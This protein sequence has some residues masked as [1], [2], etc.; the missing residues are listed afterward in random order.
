M[1]GDDELSP[2]TLDQV[3]AL[4]LAGA[5]EKARKAI[6]AGARPSYSNGRK[7][8]L[9]VLDHMMSKE[10]NIQ[11]LA[12]AIQEHLDTD[13]V[14]FYKTVVM[15]LTPKNYL[16]A[17]SPDEAVGGESVGGQDGE[18]ESVQIVRLPDNGRG[19]AHAPARDDTASDD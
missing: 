16:E 18:E 10:A 11:K 7:V 14:S 4:R 3:N 1:S 19:P 13:P 17:H 12:D 6:A 9:A 15:P 2:L 8:A 5:R